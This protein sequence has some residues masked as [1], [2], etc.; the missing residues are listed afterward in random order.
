VNEQYIEKI[1]SDFV[2]FDNDPM[3]NLNKKYKFYESLIGNIIEDTKKSITCEIKNW[4]KYE[5]KALNNV[6]N[7]CLLIID[8]SEVTSQIKKEI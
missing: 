4:P 3:V 1:L 5:N 8:E 2:H 7:S 6:V